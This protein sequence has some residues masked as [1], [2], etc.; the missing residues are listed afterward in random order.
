M[1]K[2]TGRTDQVCHDNR[3]NNIRLVLGA[4]NKLQSTRWM[5]GGGI[6]T[7][8]CKHF[9][10]HWVGVDQFIL[11]QNKHKKYP[12]DISTSIIIQINIDVKNFKTAFHFRAI[13][14]KELAAEIFPLS[15]QPAKGFDMYIS[16]DASQL[17]HKWTQEYKYYIRSTQI[18][19][20]LQ[21]SALE[22]HNPKNKQGCFVG[23]SPSTGGWV[24]LLLQFVILYSTYIRVKA[25]W[26]HVNFCM[27]MHSYADL[28]HTKVIDL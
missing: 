14:T 25:K 10:R 5:H 26:W 28:L 24:W 23:R 11:K 1:Y 21:A 16:P 12:K 7:M 20:S 3:V 13:S 17:V 15:A 22:A 2:T 8:S 9:L 18:Q 4:Q 6:R 27:C 19:E